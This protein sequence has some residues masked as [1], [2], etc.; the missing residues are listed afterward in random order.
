MQE[1]CLTTKQLCDDLCV[2]CLLCFTAYRHG[3]FNAEL[4]HFNKKFQTIQFS[5]SIAFCLNTVKCQNSFI[6]NSSV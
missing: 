1:K 5:I 3:S 2:G 6:S 4:S